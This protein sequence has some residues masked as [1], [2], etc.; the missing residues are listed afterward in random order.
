MPGEWHLVLA[1]RGRCMGGA[2]IPVGHRHHGSLWYVWFPFI[3]LINSYFACFREFHV[4]RTQ[5]HCLQ[6]IA[7]WRGA[8]FLTGISGMRN[9]NTSLVSGSCPS[10]R[11][12]FDGHQGWAPPS[13]QFLTG[14]GRRC[15]CLPMCCSAPYPGKPWV[16]FWQPQNTFPARLTQRGKSGSLQV[17][18]HRSQ[19][20][21]NS[22]WGYEKVI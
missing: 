6:F 16:S 3:L 9:S 4:L 11:G 20:R 22:I 10:L 8:R 5:R 7:L 17:P 12:H 21:K 18:P 1:T 13:L 15:E 2:G 14:R 19:G